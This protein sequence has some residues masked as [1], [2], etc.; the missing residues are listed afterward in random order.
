MVL[1]YSNGVAGMVS[2]NSGTW[3]IK[4]QLDITKLLTQRRDCAWMLA[5][6]LKH[7]VPMFKYGG[8]IPE[9]GNIGNRWLLA[10]VM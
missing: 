8:V 3:R 4:I 7:K 10:E 2:G 5:A 9:W 6:N 1:T